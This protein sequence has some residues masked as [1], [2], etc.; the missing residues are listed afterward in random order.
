MTN[1]DDEGVGSVGAR[2]T[3]ANSVL[4]ETA[5]TASARTAK[6]IV[7]NP[8]SVYSKDST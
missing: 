4:S 7:I 6:A 3:D 2:H 5:Q 1:P 8:H